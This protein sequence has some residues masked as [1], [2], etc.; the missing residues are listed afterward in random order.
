MSI[1]ED[2]K[3]LKGLYDEGLIT[4]EEYRRQKQKVL[5][6]LGRSGSDNAGGGFL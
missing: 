4:E 2:I 5:D 1:N 6:N 3:E